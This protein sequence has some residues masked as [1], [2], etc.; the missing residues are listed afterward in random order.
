[1]VSEQ[2]SGAGA[3]TIDVNCPRREPEDAAHSACEGQGHILRNI[4]H[5][6]LECD[7]SPGYWNY[8]VS[9]HRIDSMRSDAAQA[10]AALNGWHLTESTFAA[11]RI[12]KANGRCG[13][14]IPEG[15]HC[16]HLYEPNK[17]YRRVALVT[18]PYGDEARTISEVAASAPQL[19]LIT[20]LP[21]SGSWASIHFPGGTLFIVVTK[22]G[23][24]VCW[25]PEQE[26]S[27]WFDG[28]LKL[29]H[30]LLRKWDEEGSQ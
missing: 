14:D 2:T 23:M 18:Q 9:Q 26:C 16:F 4:L 30:A 7:F 12:G 6:H 24:T 11:S 20:H 15:D 25:L 29:E 17:P 10:F 13:A 22:P 3:P 8:H 21:L 1:M 5:A 27:D 19:G 28:H